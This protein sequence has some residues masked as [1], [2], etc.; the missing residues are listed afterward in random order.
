MNSNPILLVED[1]PDDVMFTLRAFKQNN[2]S[3]E[4]VVAIDGEQAL[5]ILFPEDAE[6]FWP[7]LVL[8]D[9]KLPKIDGMEVLRRIRSDPR[10]Q[11]LPVVMLTT[12]SEETDIANSYRLGANSFVRK[13]VVFSDFLNAASLLGMYWLLINQPAPEW[14]AESRA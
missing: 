13:P 1:N 12:S 8:L 10:T 2:I 3:N 6:P 14:H 5:E 4:I 11:S 9:V 7:A